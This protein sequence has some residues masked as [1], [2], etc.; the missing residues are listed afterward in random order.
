[1]VNQDGLILKEKYSHLAPIKGKFFHD[2]LLYVLFQNDK[3]KIKEEYNKFFQIF[4][5]FLT[6]IAKSYPNIFNQIRSELSG[7]YN[8]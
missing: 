6:E 5:G 2:R 8:S 7:I 4:T 3:R 1:M